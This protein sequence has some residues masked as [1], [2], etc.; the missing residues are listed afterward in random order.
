M[1][2]QIRCHGCGYQRPESEVICLR[3]LTTCKIEL[4]NLPILLREAG[5]HLQPGNGGQGSSSGERTIGVNVSALDF[6]A[7]HDLLGTLYAWQDLTRDLLGLEER[8]TLRGDVQ[9]KVENAVEFLQV[10]WEW[11]SQQTD[12]VGDFIVEIRSLHSRGIAITGQS[13]PKVRQIACPAD[14]RG[15]TC[16]RKLTVD[17]SDLHAVIQCGR[18]KTQWTTHWLIQVALSQPQADVWVDAE[19]IAQY[20]NLSAS[21][22][23]KVAKKLSVPQIGSLYNLPKFLAAHEKLVSK[24]KVL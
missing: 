24:G 4:A 5:K 17:G 16:G 18:C 3:C 11:L 12:F 9:A 20:K 7:G 1:S 2:N 10:H 21:Q 6:V 8:L 13:Q 22:V 15:T 14:Y 23:R 19:A